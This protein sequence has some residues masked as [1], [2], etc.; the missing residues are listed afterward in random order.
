MHVWD[1]DPPTQKIPLHPQKCSVWC[2]TSSTGTVRP[3]FL[4]DTV[5]AEYYPK[6]FQDHPVPT[7]VEMGVNMEETFFQHGARPYTVNVVHFV[8]EYF[9]VKVISN[10]YP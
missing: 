8:S 2:T 1:I 7:C 9:H 4:Y 6:L 10:Q 5:N 3:V